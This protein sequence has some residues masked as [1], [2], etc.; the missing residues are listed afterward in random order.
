MADFSIILMLSFIKCLMCERVAID[1][2]MPRSFALIASV[3]LSAVVAA[4][5]FL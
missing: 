4:L 5:V 2:L 1:A 3:G